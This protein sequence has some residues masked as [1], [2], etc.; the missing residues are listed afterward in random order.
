MQVLCVGRARLLP[1][2]SPTKPPNK[3][4]LV[5]REGTCSQC[6]RLWSP[7]LTQAAITRVKRLRPTPL[8]LSLPT[9]P[10]IN[11]FLAHAQ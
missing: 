11:P 6:P 5:A 10:Q 7:R 1:G 8:F 2:S 9:Q 4:P 3:G